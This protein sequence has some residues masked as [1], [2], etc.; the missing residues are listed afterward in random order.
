MPIITSTNN[1]STKSLPQIQQ[2]QYV[3]RTVKPVIEWHKG[4]VKQ[5]N[6]LSQDRR[7]V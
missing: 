4:V 5:E 7:R 3:P 6:H 2:R 1:Y